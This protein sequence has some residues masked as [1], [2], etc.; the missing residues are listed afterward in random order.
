MDIL[1][2]IKML[3]LIDILDENFAAS[4]VFWDFR[5]SFC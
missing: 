2:F 5:E 1:E 3:K 4:A